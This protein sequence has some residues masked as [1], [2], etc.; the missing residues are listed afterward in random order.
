MSAAATIQPYDPV[1]DGQKHFRALLNCTARPGTIG[2]LD[3]V[4]LEFPAGLNRAA[5]LVALTLFS[6][7][8]SFYL[9]SGDKA[10]AD[11]LRRQT[12]VFE[13]SFSEADFL[14]LNGEGGGAAIKALTLAKMGSLDFPETGAT[15]ILQVASVSPAPLGGSLRLALTGPG[16]ETESTVFVAGLSQEFLEALRVRNREFPVGIDLILACDSLSAG[17]CVLS[18]PRTTKVRWQTV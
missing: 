2:L 4:R 3:D 11:F 16:I 17:P 10:V 8:V 15:V 18:L 6:S 1:F 12:Q 13:A 7:D 14:L 9:Q 5:G